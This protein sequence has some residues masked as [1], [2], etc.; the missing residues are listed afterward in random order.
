S[1]PSVL[2]DK[3]KSTGDG[4]K[5]DH[6][7]SGANEESRDNDISRKVKLEYLYDIL[8]DTRS[9]IFTL[10]SLTDEPIIILDESEK[11]EN[12]EK[13]K[14]TKDT[15]VPPPPSPKSAQI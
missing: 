2:V 7:T 8:K 14:D 12:A 3:T 11:E 10:D 9:V 4:L 6:T 5:V 1:N 13:D 15:S